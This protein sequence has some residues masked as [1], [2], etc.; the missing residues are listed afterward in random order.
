MG[1]NLNKLFTIWMLM[2]SISWLHANNSDTIQVSNNIILFKDPRVDILQKIYLRKSDGK[3]KGLIRVQVFQAPSRERIF[4]A[5]AQFSA[6][7]PGIATFVTYVPPNF[8]LRAGEFDT[9]Q[10]ANKFMQQ[11]KPYFPAS[12][13]IEEKASPVDDK[14][15]K[16]KNY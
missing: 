9:Q 7:F 1:N 8:K 13:V 10:E 6:R 4:E 2:S 16:Q 3:K 15:P 11:V 14:K 5:K 12:F